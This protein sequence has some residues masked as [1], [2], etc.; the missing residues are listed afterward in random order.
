MG[1]G[2]QA[3]RYLEKAFDQHV[4]WLPAINVDPYYDS[5]RQHP[6]FQNI[7]QRMGL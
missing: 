7:V 5:L 3:L 1:N 6:R 2:E 4:F